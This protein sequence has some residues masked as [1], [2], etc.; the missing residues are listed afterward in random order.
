MWTDDAKHACS[1]M[2]DRLK[3]STQLSTRGGLTAPSGSSLRGGASCRRLR[4]A[5]LGAAQTRRRPQPMSAP[6]SQGNDRSALN[7]RSIGRDGQEARTYQRRATS[8]TRDSRPVPKS[9]RLPSNPNCYQRREGGRKGPTP[10]RARDGSKHNGMAPLWA[11]IAAIC[12]LLPAPI[13]P[14]DVVL[15]RWSPT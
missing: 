7:V 14:D 10:C 11:R 6:P 15:K 12:L 5:G 9:K 8:A 4:E 2:L 1:W 13:L 3:K